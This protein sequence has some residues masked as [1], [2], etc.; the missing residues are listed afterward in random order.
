MIEKRFVFVEK[1]PIEEMR[2]R[3]AAD[4]WDRGSI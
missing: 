4:L 2:S 1:R 3:N